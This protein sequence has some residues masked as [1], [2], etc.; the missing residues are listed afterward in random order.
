LWPAFSTHARIS[1][2]DPDRDSC[3]CNGLEFVRQS[4]PIFGRSGFQAS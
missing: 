2:A 4:Q 1:V 3:P